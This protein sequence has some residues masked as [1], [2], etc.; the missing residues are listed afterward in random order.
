M[1]IYFFTPSICQKSSFEACGRFI[2]K[3]DLTSADGEKGLACTSVEFRI[4]PDFVGILDSSNEKRFTSDSDIC[5]DC[6]QD[7]TAMLAKF[8]MEKL[9]REIR[10]QAILLSKADD[11]IMRGQTDIIV[12][13]GLGT[14]DPR[15]GMVRDWEAAIKNLV[16]SRNADP[17]R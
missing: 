15:L 1:C 8:R 12:L 11:I 9:E 16:D 2:C 13:A 4:N 6:E 5:H 10:R 17:Y 3:K 7:R 14:T